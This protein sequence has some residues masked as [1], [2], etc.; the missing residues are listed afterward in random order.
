MG[1][2]LCLESSKIVGAT[3][4]DGLSADPAKCYSSGVLFWLFHAPKILRAPVVCQGERRGQQHRFRTLPT[5]L[6][7]SFLPLGRHPFEFLHLARFAT[8]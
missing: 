4:G 6:E 3:F 7:S 2:A 8:V 5:A 1:L